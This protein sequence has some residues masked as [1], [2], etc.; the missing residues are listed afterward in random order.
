MKAI[1]RTITEQG[2]TTDDVFDLPHHWVT[3]KVI[4][5]R[6]NNQLYI[7]TNDNGGYIYTNTAYLLVQNTEV[8]LYDER[9]NNILVESKSNH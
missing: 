8:G 3:P 2:E 7:R 9:G 5:N 4:L 1:L 6:N